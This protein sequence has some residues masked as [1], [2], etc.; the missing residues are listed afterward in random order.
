MRRKRNCKAWL[1]GFFPRDLRDRG[2]KAPFLKAMR[3]VFLGWPQYLA[4]GFRRRYF[5]FAVGVYSYLFASL[6]IADVFESEI[7]TFFVLNFR[8]SSAALNMLVYSTIGFGSMILF[9]S[10]L[11][12]AGPKWLDYRRIPFGFCRN[13]R[14]DLR[15]SDSAV[16]PEC[17][18][19]RVPTK[20][21][22]RP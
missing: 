12:W 11:A 2:N 7:K 22:E 9:A 1:S 3:R 14:Y 19:P 6:T 16:C 8:F 10:F 15:G 20:T 18:M 21:N 13:C 17:G 4:T 5:W